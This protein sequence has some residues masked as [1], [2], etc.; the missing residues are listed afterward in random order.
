MWL[1]CCAAL[2]LPLAAQEEAT[3]PQAETP[4]EPAP[5]P[6]IEFADVPSA[7]E[8]LKTDITGYSRHNNAELLA[9]VEK[10]LPGVQATMQQINRR[11]SS[12]RGT[13]VSAQRLIAVRTSL[14]ASQRQLLGWQDSLVNNVSFCERALTETEKLIALWQQTRDNAVEAE[15]PSSVV[16]QVHASLSSVKHAHSQLTAQ[17]DAA[18]ESLGNVGIELRRV[19]SLEERIDTLLQSSRASLFRPDSPPL[20][21]IS[22]NTAPEEVWHEFK[23]FIAENYEVLVHWSQR[24]FVA[25]SIWVGC[26]FAALIFILTARRQHLE[27]L[28][29][30]ERL[31]T[32]SLLAHHPISTAV[33]LVLL[34]VPLLLRERTEAFGWLTMAIAAPALLRLVPTLIPFELR[35]LARGTVAIYIVAKLAFMF[36]EDSNAARLLYLI[37][38][39]VIVMGGGKHLMRMRTHEEKHPVVT[40]ITRL[41]V[42]LAGVS[43]LA[44]IFGLSQLG[45]TIMQGT[46]ASAFLGLSLMAASVTVMAFF[47][48][49][50]ILGPLRHLTS[51]KLHFEV[52]ERQLRRIVFWFVLSLWTLY[53]LRAFT[54]NELVWDQL[55]AMLH[56]EWQFG[57][58]TLTLSA[59]LWFFLSVALAVLASRIIRFFLENDVLNRMGLPRGVPSTISMMLNY[60]IITLGF[61]VALAAV[62]IEMSQLSILIGALGVGIGFGLQNVVNNF[63][64]GL[65]LIFERPISEG[66]IVQ[67][68]T[69]TGKVTR[70]GLRS[71]I[72]RTFEG[73]EIIV[74]NGNLISNE[75]TNWTLSD[76]TR[77]ITI[78]VRVAFGTDT[79]QLITLLQDTANAHDMVLPDPAPWA[80]F[81]NFGESSLNF[82][83]RCWAPADRLLKAKSTLTIDVDRA[84]R[85]AGIVMPYP[86]T[87]VKWQDRPQDAP[88]PPTPRPPAAE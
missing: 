79:Q 62:G 1:L 37:T 18:L 76:Q 69:T 52:V 40:N 75:V 13:K 36:P 48:L 73:A 55:Q 30:D 86:R 11:I 77:R 45:A 59:L 67:F 31:Q 58:L 54:I 27:R 24:H 12:I 6:S 46:S 61:L 42:L 4:A 81:E 47:R 33:L 49:I 60:G 5:P 63:T 25:L 26:F 44:H 14:D 70:I 23:L 39:I 87:E 82:S 64:S 66:D 56:R 51:I 57:S 2:T 85:E 84:L 7:A 65:I 53:S 71:S 17:H 88:P 22:R 3:A 43:M 8:Q 80:V 16:R 19:N 9:R 32:T 20:W 28:T 38:E 83:L 34:L 29:S 41:M 74:P 78:P 68:G 72:V 50:A 10:D 21:A 35:R 15:A